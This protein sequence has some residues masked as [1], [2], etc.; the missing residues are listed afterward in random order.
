[1]LTGIHTPEL[2]GSS[3]SFLWDGFTLELGD[4]GSFDGNRI[5]GRVGGIHIE[6]RRVREGE[7][8]PLAGNASSIRVSTSLTAMRGLLS[9]Q[10]SV[11]MKVGQLDAAAAPVSIYLNLGFSI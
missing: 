5:P 11:P 1:V 8:M 3:L 9:G 2:V 6:E 4:Y 7:S 10:W